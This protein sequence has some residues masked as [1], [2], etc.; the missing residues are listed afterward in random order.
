MLT[1]SGSVAALLPGVDLGRFSLLLAVAGGITVGAPLLFGALNYRFAS[2][3]P[4]TAGVAAISLPQSPRSGRS[5]TPG[6]A[7]R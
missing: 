6:R 3:D 2:V 5:P 4:T 1:A 7:R